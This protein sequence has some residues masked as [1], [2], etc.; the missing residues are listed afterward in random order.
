MISSF[1]DGAAL[2]VLHVKGS[3]D[4]SYATINRFSSKRQS[5]WLLRFC[6]TQK[7]GKSIFND[8]RLLRQCLSCMTIPLSR[9]KMTKPSKK[10]TPLT[11]AHLQPLPL[12]HISS[13]CFLG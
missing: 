12:E 3:Q 11:I 13:K 9:Q 1:A 10:F 7:L 6:A 5:F 4:P 8:V 2:V